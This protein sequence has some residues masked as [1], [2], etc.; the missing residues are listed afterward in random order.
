MGRNASTSTQRTPIRLKPVPVSCGES[1][2]NRVSASAFASP[3]IRRA[4]LRPGAPMIPAAGMRR[5]PAHPEI[6]ESASSSAPIPAPDAGRTADRGSARRERYCLRSARTPAPDRAASAPGGAGRSGGCWARTPASV[7]TTASPKASR[8][9][10]QVPRASAVRRVLHEAREDVLPRRRD[11][12]IGQRRDDH[13]DVRPAGEGAVLRL[14]VGALH[15]VDARRDGDGPAQVIAGAWQAGEIGQ[16][17]E[18]EIHLGRRSAKAIAP[19]A[20]RRNRPAARARR[21]TGE[22]SDGDRRSTARRPHRAR[23][24]WPA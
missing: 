20:R 24:R 6:L 3:R 14:I 11:R 23:R 7:S 9:S 22:T 5:R 19:H 18:R 12:R 4:A 16:R 2:A 13:V 10:S 1:G 21:R 8:C 15:V 17:V